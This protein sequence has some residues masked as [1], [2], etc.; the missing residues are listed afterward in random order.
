MDERHVERLP[1]LLRRAAVAPEDDDLV[2]GVEKLVRHGRELRPPVAVER[3]EDVGAHLGDAVVDAAMR[4]PLRLLPLDGVVHVGEDRRHV[5]TGERL[6]GA[7][8]DRE[9]HAHAVEPTHCV[10][11]RAL[12]VGASRRVA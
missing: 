6:V 9:V 1:R 11:G 4:E 7:L 12:D 5:A 2:A 8:D 10:C 3:V